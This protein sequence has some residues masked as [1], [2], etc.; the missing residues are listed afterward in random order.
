MMPDNTLAVLQLISPSNRVQYHFQ[1]Q[2]KSSSK[3]ANN[4]LEEWSGVYHVITTNGFEFSFMIC[5]QVFEII[6][7]YHSINLE[8]STCYR[9][10]EVNV[11]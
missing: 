5:R 3:D 10:W 1:T 6:I 9:N 8:K 4:S 11:L 2:V 7:S